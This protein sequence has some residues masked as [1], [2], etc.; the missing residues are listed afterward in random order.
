[1]S[2]KDLGVLLGVTEDN[3]GTYEKRGTKPKDHLIHEL[4]GIFGIE[5]AHLLTTPLKKEDYQWLFNEKVQF[6]QFRNKFNPVFKEKEQ[7]EVLNVVNE[8]PFPYSP[9]DELSG[10]MLFNLTES[11]RILSESNRT[12]AQA[13]KQLADNNVLLTTKCFTA[14]D[15]PENQINVQAMLQALQEYLSELSA[16]VNKTT[17]AK[18]AAELGKRMVD[19]KASLGKK[20]THVDGGK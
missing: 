3:I 14:G 8:P 11:Q 16:K 2:Q 5:Y 19:K 10:R 18:T 7:Q 9:R 4:A 1:M 17:V 20:D 6:P 15:D 12:I 13:N